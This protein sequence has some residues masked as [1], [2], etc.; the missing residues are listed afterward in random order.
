MAKKQI[1]LSAFKPKDTFTFNLRHPATDEKLDITITV[2]SSDSKKYRAV[3]HR[4]RN[5][6]MGKRNAKVTS[7]QVENNAVEILVACTE[8]WD[9]MLYDGQALECTPANVRMIYIALPWVYEQV[10]AAIGDRTN[11]LG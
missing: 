11:F 8:S 10:D 3:V 5:E 1:D 7:E 4:L 6:R 2:C 9:N